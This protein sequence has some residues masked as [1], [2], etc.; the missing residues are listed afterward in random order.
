MAS[1]SPSPAG[2]KVTLISTDSP[3]PTATSDLW[4]VIPVLPTV[5]RHVPADS[6]RCKGVRPRKVPPSPTNS[7]TALG[8]SDHSLTSPLVFRSLAARMS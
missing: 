1:G 7:T 3:T 8:G 6:H 2:L 4:G 5:S